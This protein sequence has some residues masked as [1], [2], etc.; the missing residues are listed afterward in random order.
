MLSMLIHQI[1]I[2]MVF[3]FIFLNIYIHEFQIDKQRI[4][5]KNNYGGSFKLPHQ[6]YS[7][8]QYR[9]L[10]GSYKLSGSGNKPM[11]IGKK[12]PKVILRF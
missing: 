12:P 3:N 8:K 1:S 6:T 2:F 5:Y 7:L 10:G 11:K 9:L 4:F